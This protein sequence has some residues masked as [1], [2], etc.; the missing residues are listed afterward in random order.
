[1]TA[2]QP[3]GGS[4]AMVPGVRGQDTAGW[5]ASWLGG[6]APPISWLELLSFVGFTG[7][8]Q[9]QNIVNIGLSR[10]IL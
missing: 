4:G 7:D 1:M 3:R 5:L 2:G 9:P 10:K 6:G 8:H